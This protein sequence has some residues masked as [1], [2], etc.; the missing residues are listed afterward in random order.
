MAHANLAHLMVISSPNGASSR[1][2]ACTVPCVKANPRPLRATL[3]AAAASINRGN[4]FSA[5]NQLL[6]FEHQIRA[7][8][9]PRDPLL[10][11]SLIQSAQDVVDAFRAEKENEWLPRLI[12]PRIFLLKGLLWRIDGRTRNT[13]PAPICHDC[14]WR[15]SQGSD[16][17]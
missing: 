13:G 7:Q 5:A 17:P 9:A 3:A 12:I 2:S 10:A 8:A 11:Q 1:E 6:A 4:P 16:R 14:V 15:S